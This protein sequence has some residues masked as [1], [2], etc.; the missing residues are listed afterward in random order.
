MM[1]SHKKQY[2]RSKQKAI[3]FVEIQKKSKPF[4]QMV[5]ALTNAKCQLTSFTGGRKK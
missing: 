5:K 3:V 4:Q 2:F 1:F